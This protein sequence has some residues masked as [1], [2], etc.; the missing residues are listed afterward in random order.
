M[1]IK[2]VGK[3]WGQLFRQL[4]F[5]ICQI[6][7]FSSIWIESIIDPDHPQLNMALL[8]KV[9]LPVHHVLI[10]LLLNLIIVHKLILLNFQ[11]KKVVF[12]IKKANRDHLHSIFC[13][14]FNHYFHRLRLSRLRQLEFLYQVSCLSQLPIVLLLVGLH[15]RMDQ[16]FLGVFHYW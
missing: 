12:L 15:T 10:S 4:I 3:N 1:L 7:R 14:F 6:N 2:S 9:L 8:N 5:P 13:N 11:R 16:H